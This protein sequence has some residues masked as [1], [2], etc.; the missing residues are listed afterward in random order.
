MVWSKGKDSPDDGA[1]RAVV[2]EGGDLAQLV[3][4]GAHEQELVA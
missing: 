2:D 3:A 1:Q 4:A